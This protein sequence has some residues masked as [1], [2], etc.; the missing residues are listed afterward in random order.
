M[1]AA[2][3][4]CGCPH[5]LEEFLN[6]H[7]KLVPATIRNATRLSARLNQGGVLQ[8]QHQTLQ[9]LPVVCR[10]TRRPVRMTAR[11]QSWEGARGMRAPRRRDIGR[12]LRGR[13]PTSR[14]RR[15]HQVGASATTAQHV[16]SGTV[17]DSRCT[18]LMWGCELAVAHGSGPGGVLCH[19]YA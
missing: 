7:L 2:A 1:A 6:M 8:H 11:R 3:V 4:T 19:S 9:V 5:S 16:D 15:S 13:P 17:R 14:S 12:R 10:R 18:I